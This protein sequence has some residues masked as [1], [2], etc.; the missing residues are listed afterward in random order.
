MKTIILG[1]FLSFSV[2]AQSQWISNYSGHNFGDNNFSNAKGLANT[3]D[4]YGNCYVTGFS[5]NDFTGNDIIVIKYSP[6][7][8]TLWTLTYNGSGNS[9]DK[10]YGIVVDNI[11]NIYITGT[12]NISGKGYDIILLKLSVSGSLLWSRNYGGEGTGEDKAYGITVDSE[13]NIIITGYYTGQF[14]NS[15]IITMKYDPYGSPIWT[16]FIME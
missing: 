3:V 14:G 8:D 15:D 16:E 12:A 1:L 5:Y 10:G 2:I 9:D 13:S 7:G 6:M 11:G 4:S